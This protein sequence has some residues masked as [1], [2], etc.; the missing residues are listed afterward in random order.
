MPDSNAG[1]EPVS[2]HRRTAIATL[3][4]SAALI[5]ATQPAAAAYHLARTIAIGGEGGWDYLTVDAATHRLFVSHSTL[6]NVLDIEK[7]AVIGE[8]PDTPGVHG[9]ALAPA[10][11]RGFVSNGRAGTVTVFDLKN[12]SVISTVKVTGENPDAI[13]FEPVSR[14][15]F[16]FNGRSGNA[17]AIDAKDAK[18]LGTLALG[19]KP[20]FAVADGHGRIY[21]NIEDTGEIAAIDATAL[22]IEG[23]WPLAPCQEPSGLAMDREH[24]RLFSVCGNRLMAVVDA[25]SGRVIT[26]LPTGS[27]TDGAAFDP[28]TGFAFSSNGEGTVT[29]VREESPDA[30]T[31]VGN[32]ATKRGARTIALDESTHRIYLSTAQFGPPPS[33]TPEN[34]RPRPKVLPG[35][36][37]VLVLEP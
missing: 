14:R 23:R 35:T 1:E 2:N 22:K 18:V 12:L 16:A 24:R 27:G 29:V 26:T 37:E 10:L 34:P 3:V 30:F 36:F 20:E 33:P 7:G 17:T 11:D 28:A 13:A 9:I 15:V 6:V 21:V 8:I 31:V 25:D 5:A 4:C 32:V 19:G